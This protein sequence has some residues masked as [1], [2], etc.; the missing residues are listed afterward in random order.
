LTKNSDATSLQLGS[1]YTNK[2]LKTK[3]NY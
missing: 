3:M 1:N 2:N